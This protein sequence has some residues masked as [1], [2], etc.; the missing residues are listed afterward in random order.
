MP[1]APVTTSANFTF[2]I[3]GKD[4][5]STKQEKEAQDKNNDFATAMKEFE[6][7]QQQLETFKTMLDSPNL[8]E[9]VSNKLQEVQQ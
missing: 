6:K 2:E 3:P 7:T 1:Q 9:V 4:S 5:G 8:N